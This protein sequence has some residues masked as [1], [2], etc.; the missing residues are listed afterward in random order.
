MS[1][2]RTLSNPTVTINDDTIGI[3]PNS[4]VYKP[5][6]GDKNVRAQSSGGNAIDAV[7]TENAETKISMVKFKLYN[8]KTNLDI[9]KTWSANIQ[10]TIQLSENDDIVENFSGMVVG[11][12]PER[13]IGA[14]GDLEIEFM[15]QPS[16]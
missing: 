5:G 9:V 10:N 12:E 15:G 7:V 8:T 6:L 1:T 2:L 11:P 14:D 13:N 3:V 4:L 16:L